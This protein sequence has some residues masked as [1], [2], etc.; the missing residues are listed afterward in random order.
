MGIHGFQSVVVAHH[1]GLPVA[2][3]SGKFAVQR[4]L[5]S[6]HKDIKVD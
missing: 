6:E 5:K 3:V 1:H 2:A 4:I